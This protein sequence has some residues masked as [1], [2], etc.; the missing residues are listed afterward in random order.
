MQRT[1]AR[2]EPCVRTVWAAMT[3]SASLVSPG[4]TAKKVKGTRDRL[5]VRIIVYSCVIATTSSLCFMMQMQHFALWKKTRAARSSANRATRLTSVP[6]LVGGSSAGR[7]R[8][9]VSRQVCLLGWLKQHFTL[10]TF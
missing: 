1:P 10:P 5:P 2:T 6:A 8:T 3:A 4:S 7:T 9:S